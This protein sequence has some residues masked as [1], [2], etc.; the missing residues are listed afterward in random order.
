MVTVVKKED[1]QSY[2]GKE[3]GTSE[4]L[5]I[6]QPRI[7]M[8]AEATNDHQFIH[9]DEKAAAQTPFGGTIAHGFLSLSLLS[10]LA[11]SLAIIPEGMQMG[12]NYG[13][14][15]VRFISPVPVNSEVRASAVLAGMEEKSPG[16]FFMTLAV[17][18]EIKGEEK[19]ALIAEWLTL[20]VSG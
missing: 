3:L 4:W 2:V 14:N 1:L 5:L 7:N 10:F 6:D 12:I 17:T 20:W 18:I 11:G 8:F 19:P 9:V 13:L 15:K 16:K